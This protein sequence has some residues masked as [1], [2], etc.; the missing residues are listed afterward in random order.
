MYHL[1]I[2]IYCIWIQTF[3]LDIRIWVPHVE[4]Q[5][6]EKWSLFRFIQCTNVCRSTCIIT[7]HRVQRYV[8][9]YLLKGTNSITVSLVPSFSRAIHLVAHFGYRVQ[10]SSWYHISNATDILSY[11]LKL[12]L[13]TSHFLLVSSL[14]RSLSISLFIPIVH[15]FGPRSNRIEHHH[16]SGQ[17]RAR[18]CEHI[19]QRL[20]QLWSII[21]SDNNLLTIVFFHKKEYN[22]EFDVKLEITFWLTF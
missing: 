20:N 16:T 18:H 3:H 21:F 10:H 17:M 22:Y 4:E 2:E 9:L 15:C 13:I 12:T 19:Y 1:Y 8:Q 6:N 7:G 11:H 14:S 5:V